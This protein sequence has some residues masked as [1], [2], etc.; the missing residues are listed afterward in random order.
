MFYW[1][2]FQNTLQAVDQT[3]ASLKFKIVS[4]E[5][6]IRPKGSLSKL[7]NYSS[8]DCCSCFFC[9]SCSSAWAA[10]ID[11]LNCD[12]FLLLHVEVWTV[13]WTVG[14]VY[15]CCC[16]TPTGWSITLAGTADPTLQVIEGAEGQDAAADW[17]GRD[18]ALEISR[19]L[20]KRAQTIQQRMGK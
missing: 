3:W 9:L 15:Y 16:D 12:F 10:I 17:R 18:H 20:K 19:D 5:K 4:G 14:S 11:H 1:F 6:L 8:W 13:N 2:C 7:N